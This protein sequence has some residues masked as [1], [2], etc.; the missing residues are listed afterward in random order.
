LSRRCR[1]GNSG[2]TNSSSS[3]RARLSTALHHAPSQVT[4]ER[5]AGS[6]VSAAADV[7]V[8]SAFHKAL[9]ASDAKRLNGSPVRTAACNRSSRGLGRC[10]IIYCVFC[11]NSV[12]VSTQVCRAA[13]VDGIA[14]QQQQQQSAAHRAAPVEAPQQQ[15]QQQGEALQQLSFS[16][17]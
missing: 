13:A 9:L 10:A 6:S 15:Q 12:P 16:H 8:L 1:N 2:A 3:S 14:N 4:S 5:Q 7:H 17:R 11:S